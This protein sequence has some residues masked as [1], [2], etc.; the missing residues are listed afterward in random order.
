MGDFNLTP[1]KS[2]IKFI[3]KNLNDSKLV[4]KQLPFGPDETFNGFK[5]CDDRNRRIDYIFVSQ[6]N[7]TVEKYGVFANVKKMKYPSDHFPV[8]INAKIK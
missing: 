1:E 6:K 4:S 2:P 5:V 8:Y 7:I 3:A